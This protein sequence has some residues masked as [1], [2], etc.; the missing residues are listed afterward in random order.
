MDGCTLIS[1]GMDLFLERCQ[2][3]NFLGVNYESDILFYSMYSELYYT[4]LLN[5]LSFLTFYNDMIFS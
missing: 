5:V 1:E 4:F 3:Y 2:S